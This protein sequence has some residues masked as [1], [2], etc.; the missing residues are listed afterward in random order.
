[1][2]AMLKRSLAALLVAAAPLLT[3][4]GGSDDSDATAT[5]PGAAPSAST[6]SSAGGSG[7]SCTYTEDG[8]DASV[9]LPPAQARYTA[10]TQATLT[11]SGGAVP[12]T[13]RGADAPCTVNSFASLAEQG[14]F[15]GT[16]CHRLTTD[17][18]YVLQCGDPT[19]TGTG[20]PGYSFGDE[21]KSAEAL[22]DDP[23]GQGAKNYA[24]G[25]VAMA[26][27]GPDTNGSQFFLV[28]ADSPLPPSYTVFGTM[29][30]AGLKVVKAIA[31]QGTADGS[32]DGSPK[33]PTTIEKVTVG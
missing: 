7:P 29:D 3:A 27:A 14:Y 30:A 19:G 21:L 11:L 13:L 8:S 22:E 10:D 4:C 31:D 2:R 32:S 24:A 17:G 26:N 12:V 15:D 23:V 5:D 25:T 16:T 18:I 6:S 20:G 33:T 28:Y 9:K 1:M